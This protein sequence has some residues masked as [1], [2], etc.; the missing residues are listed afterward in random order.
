MDA[1]GLLLKVVKTFRRFAIKTEWKRTKCYQFGVSLSP[2]IIV[3]AAFPNSMKTCILRH[4]A[5]KFPL[6]MYSFMNNGYL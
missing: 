6:K 3:R 4:Y 2:Y 5:T 1:N